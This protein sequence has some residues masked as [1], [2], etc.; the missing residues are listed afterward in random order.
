MVWRAT[1]PSSSSAFTNL[2]CST[3][4]WFSPEILPV[5]TAVSAVVSSSWNM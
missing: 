2:K 5:T 1:W 3:N 4:G